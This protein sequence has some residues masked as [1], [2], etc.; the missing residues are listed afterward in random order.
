MNEESSFWPSFFH[1]SSFILHLSSFILHPSS[2]ILHL[3]SFI[4]HLSS[5]ILHPSSFILHPSS[6]ILH[7]SSFNFMAKSVLSRYLDFDVLSRMADRHIEPRGLVVGN[8]AGA[9]KSPLSGFAVEFA[10]HREYVPGD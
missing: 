5:F 3:S 2:F 6:F 9:H 1:P 7:P 4:F 10:S 8:L